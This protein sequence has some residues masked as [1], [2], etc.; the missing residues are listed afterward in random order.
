[1]PVVKQTGRLSSILITCDCAALSMSMGQGVL[2]I[3]RGKQLPTLH[4][5]CNSSRRDKPLSVFVNQR[6]I[7]D[8]VA[9]VIKA[10]L[11][12]EEINFE[13]LKFV[14][15]KTMPEIPH[16]YVKRTPENERDYVA[17]FNAIMKDGVVEKWRGKPYRYWYRGDG[18][19][20]WAM[21]SA[22]GGQSLVI[23]RAEVDAPTSKID[24]ESGA[25]S[26]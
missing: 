3:G 2:N 16:Y 8:K 11:L 21:T 12:R 19:K 26:P 14:F 1:M 13:N 18:Y 4:G 7:A 22:L 15:A 24:E 25:I 9:P 17:L 6:G 10:Y 5:S 23:N 20:Y